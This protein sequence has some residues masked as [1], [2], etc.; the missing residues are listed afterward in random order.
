MTTITVAVTQVA[1]KGT[2]DEP[3]DVLRTRML[4]AHAELVGKASVLGVNIIGFQEVFNQAYFCPSRDPKWFACA[5][6]IPGG[7]TIRFVSDLARRYAM[8]IVAP[9]YEIGED[10]N[11][12]CAAAVI[13]ADGSYLGKYRKVHIRNAP[14]DG[15]GIE[16]LFFSNG[17]LGYPVF[18]T[19]YARVGVYICFD[20]HFPEGFRELGLRGAQ[21]VFNPSATTVNLS[22]YMWKIEQPAAAVANGFYVCTN[23]RVGIEEP[24]TFGRFYGSSYIVS[25]E[26][27]ILA[28]G[29]TDKDEVVT[30]QID[31]DLVDEVQR[32]WNIFESRQ[33][34]TYTS[35]LSDPQ[36][37]ARVRGAESWR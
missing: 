3:F 17:N 35:I 21:V 27:R 9:I 29:S 18:Q 10:G 24:W 32:R 30:A 28:T 5:E 31:L 37:L 13:D 6:P 4:D 36:P 1:L 11:Y 16:R 14:T 26:G 20:R 8:V 22:E 23:N 15:K 7:P 12:Y 19:R 2:T 34:S 33:A 25:P